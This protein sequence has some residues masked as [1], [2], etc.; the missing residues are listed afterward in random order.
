MATFVCTEIVNSTCLTW[1]EQV[2]FLPA[3]TTEQGLSISSQIILC[4]AVAWGFRTLL[5]FIFNR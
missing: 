1:S 5:R 2:G 4:M 3:L